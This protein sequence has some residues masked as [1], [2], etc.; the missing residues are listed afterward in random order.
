MYL[1]AAGQATSSDIPWGRPTGH[2]WRTAIPP[3][4]GVL[5]PRRGADLYHDPTGPT[6]AEE[7]R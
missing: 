1:L 2:H 6:G 3:R 4:L 5:H 7:D